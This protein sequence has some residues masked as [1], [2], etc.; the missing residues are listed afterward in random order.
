MGGGGLITLM[1]PE[2]RGNNAVSNGQSHNSDTSCQWPAAQS[3]ALL[4]WPR[5]WFIRC[6]HVRVSPLKVPGCQREKYWQILIRGGGGRGPWP[7]CLHKTSEICMTPVM[8]SWPRV[9]VILRVSHTCDLCLDCGPGLIR[10]CHK[11]AFLHWDSQLRLN[12]RQGS[13]KHKWFPMVSTVQYHF[14]I[15]YVGRQRGLL[16]LPSKSSSS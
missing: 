9:W 7:E 2:K 11:I 5:F 8:A 4:W 13:G 14:I 10:L 12:V 15:R 16:W 3:L 6:D 1:G